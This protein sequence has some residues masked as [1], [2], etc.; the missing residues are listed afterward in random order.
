MTEYCPPIDPNII[1]FIQDNTHAKEENIHKFGEVYSPIQ[2]AC[3]MLHKI[4][5]AKWRDPALVWFDPACGA[6]IFMQVVYYKLMETL[7]AKIPEKKK[8][9]R[10]ILEKMLF[11]A[12]IQSSNTKVSR[13]I[14]REID[15][16]SK[17]NIFT[18]D[19]LESENSF[20]LKFDII[21]GNP[22]YNSGGIHA[23]TT[24]KK[25]HAKQ[26]GE[27]SRKTLWPLF[28]QKSLN[29]L[30]DES[31][32]LLFIHPVSWMRFKGKNGA[33]FSGKQLDF[34]R[35]YNLAKSNE[36]FGGKSGRI[37][38]AYYLLEN[39]PPYA[40]TN[41]YDNST[42]KIEKFDIAKYQFIPTESISLWK[43]LMLVSEKYGTLGKMFEKVDVPSSRLSNT[44][45]KTHK[46][47]VVRYAYKQ[48]KIQYLNVDKNRSKSEK[49]IF[50]NE[51]MG[52]PIYDEGGTLYPPN[53]NY[54]LRSL[55][56]TSEKKRRELKQWQQYFYS[57]LLLYLISTMKVR[58]NFF[59]DKIFEIIPDISKITRSKTIEDTKLIEWFQLDENDL[60]GYRNY[61][62][63]GEGKLGEYE[64]QQLLNMG[65]KEIMELGKTAKKIKQISSPQTRKIR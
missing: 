12:D 6:G 64:K 50:T 39:R 65:K 34:I 49:L 15:S 27:E 26:E 41:I 53:D 46:Y 23:K 13:A 18:E 4:P 14:F 58:Q 40:E 3:E 31:S 30:R 29:L 19:F 8:R 43:K 55:A 1:Q 24:D 11:M 51:S 22:P 36:L 59:N 38:V 17:P 56:G 21:V 9:S 5:A 45:T 2:L 57:N 32:L 48:M 33:L 7:S 20:P 25:K 47:P 28:V 54:I 16:S 61:L 52:Y 42:G 63:R 60:I 62:V 10:H 44:K 37:P 35:Y